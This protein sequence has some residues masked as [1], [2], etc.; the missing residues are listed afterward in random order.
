MADIVE[1]ANILCRNTV[2]MVNHITV[3]GDAE[4]NGP[5]VSILY[6]KVTNILYMHN[7]K[8]SRS[9]IIHKALFLPP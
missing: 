8:E 9:K 7:C 2:N 4:A 5:T 1:Q 3:N 6:I